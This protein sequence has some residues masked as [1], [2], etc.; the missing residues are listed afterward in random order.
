M[1]CGRQLSER[2][3][4]RLERVHV[5][6]PPRAGG[7]QKDSFRAARLQ[8]K[9]G[10]T[11]AEYYVRSYGHLIPEGVEIIEYDE[12]SGTAREVVLKD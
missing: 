12:E 7:I 3:D 10:E 9:R 1:D 2:E 11:L 6:L 5:S 8:Q 4:Y